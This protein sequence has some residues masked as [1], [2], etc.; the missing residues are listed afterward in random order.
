MSSGDETRRTAVQTQGLTA[1]EAAARL[2]RDGA[3][4]LPVAAPPPAW[5]LLLG[6]MV[7]FFAVLLWVAGGLAF[8]AGMPELG[9]A[10]FVVVVING[11]FAFF[12]EHRAERAAE[13]L[14]DLLPRRATV[15]RDGAP[16]EVDASEL[17]V[18]DV[19]ALGSGD[20]VSADLRVLEAHALRL[21]TSTLTG[22]SVPVSVEADDVAL[23]G[24][25]VVEG[26][27]FAVVEAT[28]SDTRLSG[29]ASLTG[30]GERPRTPLARELDRVVR[31]VAAVAVSV[32]AVFFAVS[33][34]VGTPASSGF[35]FAI[36]VTVALVPEG[37]LPTITLSL[38]MGAQRMAARHALVR[39]L[40]S[41]ET[42][43]STTFICTDKTGTL[44]RNEMSVVEA[45]TPSG[46][47]GVSGTGYAPE[48]E[49]RA[50]ASAYPAIRDLARVA[51]R[52]STG[53][54]VEREGRWVARGDP[55][56]AA[57]YTFA[58]RAGVDVED[59]E[60]RVPET[61]RFP[62][63]PRRRRMSVVV[64]ERLLVK[65]APDSVLPGC[66]ETNGAEDRLAEMAQKGLRVIAVAARN[67]TEVPDNADEA[68][69]D[70]ELLG[71]VGLEDPPR[72]AAAG[73][74][75]ACR[76]AGI[77]LAMLTGDHPS[78]AEAIAKEV[79][80][81]GE[82]SVIVEGRELPEDEAMLGALLD[83]DGVVVSRVEPEDKLRIAHALQAR[84][85][86][87]A[88]TGDGVN[89]GPA[90]QQADIGIAMGRSGTD[91]AR[92]AADLVLLND[93]FATIVAA[94]EQGRATF[95]N[96]RRFLTYHL[97]DNVAELT[98]FVV[99]ALSGGQFPL[100]L[101]V[102]QILALD[103][104]TDLLPSLALGA[105][106]PRPDSLKEPPRGRHL[107][108]GPLLRRV[109]GVLG[110]AEALVE[111]SAFVAALAAAGWRPGESFP[112][113]PALL[114][115]SGAA[116]AAVVLGQMAN[117]FAC[118]STTRWAGSLG[119]TSNRL[120]VG[121][122]AFELL[123]LAGF[124]F[125]GPVASLLGHAP[126]PLWG[127]AVAALAAPAVLLADAVHKAARRRRQTAPKR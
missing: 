75:A 99:W 9:V 92:E 56:E 64:G 17:V 25:F 5:R 13:R 30:T 96:V 120:L 95:A 85:H 98:P 101:G 33:L 51:A 44:T 34:L 3:N 50:E 11:V 114:A 97:T 38:A 12:Q 20:R 35:L 53:R 74:V 119:W 84:G 8:V 36:G 88:M 31:T 22:E 40:E 37:L 117:A 1:A 113:G 46:A 48:G 54:A 108:D 121:A 103:I 52:C 72:E 110:P 61:R 116:F 19:V 62:F 115:A 105:E 67:I 41:V 76:Q 90:L 100:A 118:R 49:V 73:A 111:M 127:W 79:G 16:V 45:W 86:V 47:A 78:T 18:G 68:E 104:G 87:V 32:G 42:L 69:R 71:L 63:D 2:R 109:F 28:G 77:R 60:R 102:L 29:I 6:Q 59:D 43:G 106:P 122:V 39:H 21:D 26:E 4:V 57:L 107:I 94:V 80:L 126:P 82:E 93:D 58:R 65:G 23:A 14:R 81:L 15:V 125:V 24:T 124:L 112:T 123:A 91:V 83:R 89:D 10:I 27:G 66:R 70:L 7:H 55:M